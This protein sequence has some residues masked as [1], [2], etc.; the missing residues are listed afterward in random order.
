M[1]VEA[2]E[3]AFVLA[4]VAGVEPSDQLQS[5]GLVAHSAEG[6]SG[7]SDWPVV[8]LIVTVEFLAIALQ[9]LFTCF[10]IDLD[11]LYG[12]EPQLP[13]LSESHGFDE[14]LFDA[15]NRVKF[16]LEERQNDG[17]ILRALVI[18][19]D[20]FREQSVP[21]RVLGRSDFPSRVTAPVDFAELAEDAR[22]PSSVTGPRDFAPLA[23]EAWILNEE[24]ISWRLWQRRLATVGSSGV[25]R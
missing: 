10:T 22:L 2:G 12:P 6:E 25:N 1:G 16:V 4:V 7:E 19:N 23:R 5:A 24:L 17:E 21:G 3:G 18:E 20:R 9:V 15:G 11:L 8:D 13:P 14:P